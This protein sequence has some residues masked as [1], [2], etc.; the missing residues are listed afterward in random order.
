MR[1]AGIIK[2]S[3]V[4]GIGIRDVIFTQG[5]QHHCKGCHNPKTW[6]IDGNVIYEGKIG[7]DE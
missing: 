1:I 4:N 3:V 2:D 6:D 5:C 7:T